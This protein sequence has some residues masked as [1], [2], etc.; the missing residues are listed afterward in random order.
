FRSD[1]PADDGPRPVAA[2]RLHRNAAMSTP[3]VGFIYPDHAAESDYS[4]AAQLLGVSLPVVHIYGTDLHAVPELMDLGSPARLAQ[5]A[6][7]LEPYSTDAVVW[8]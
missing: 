8:A 6:A 7:L 3:A 5:G 2:R 4:H 1:E